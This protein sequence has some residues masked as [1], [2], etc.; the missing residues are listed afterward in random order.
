METG[1]MN[2][3]QMPI[4]VTPI[5]TAT[6]ATT[7]QT[8]NGEE[9]ASSAFAEILNGLTPRMQPQPEAPPTETPETVA[10]TATA[11]LAQQL[12]KVIA[13][14]ANVEPPEADAVQKPLLDLIPQEVVMSVAGAQL[15]LAQQ[16]IGRMPAANQNSDVQIDTVN[17]APASSGRPLLKTDAMEV[18]RNE[19]T[20]AMTTTGKVAS[21][22]VPL[23][24][25]T[26]LQIPSISATPSDGPVKSPAINISANQGQATEVASPER[27][28]IDDD[29]LAAANAKTVITVAPQEPSV[30][31][32]ALPQR[33]APQRPVAKVDAQPI[34]KAASTSVTQPLATTPVQQVT[35]AYSRT[36]PAASATHEAAALPE[37]A[38]R[39]TLAQP[40]QPAQP[41]NPDNALKEETVAPTK[42]ASARQEAVVLTAAQPD[43]PVTAVAT[44]VMQ[45]QAVVFAAAAPEVVE[46]MRVETVI[47][48]PV[49]QTPKQFLFIQESSQRRPVGTLE[50]QTA[51]EIPVAAPVTPVA[52]TKVQAVPAVSL[53]TPAAPVF[54][55]A[56]A[57][58][59]VVPAAS[60]ASVIAPG[61]P[62]ISVAPVATTSA[63]QSKK[64][65]DLTVDASQALH[66]ERSARP[67]VFTAPK[68]AVVIAASE[69]VRSE[70]V[71]KPSQQ[72]SPKAPAQKTMPAAAASVGIGTSDWATPKAEPAPQTMR[73]APLQ[74]I[75]EAY[76]QPLAVV[77]ASPAVTVTAAETIPSQLFDKVTGVNTDTA[78]KNSGTP[79]THEPEVQKVTAFTVPIAAALSEQPQ[80]SAT[81]TPI[82]RAVETG[83]LPIR[84]TVKANDGPVLVE[85]QHQHTPAAT[86]V[87]SAAKA[88]LV[89]AGA[90]KEMAAAT[91]G[92]DFGSSNNSRS[93][94][95]MNG[96]AHQTLPQQ[97]KAETAPSAAPVANSATSGVAEQVAKQVGEHFAKHE[98]KAGS[99]QIVIR[100]NPDNL[101]E[102]K[103]NLRMENQ[104]VTIEIVT[105]NRT[106][107]DSLLQN[108]D[109]LKESLAKQNI[110]MDSFDVSTGS[111]NQDNMAG[112][113]GRN[114]NDWQELAKNRQVQQ[115]QQGGYNVPKALVPE[116]LAYIPQRQ[117]TMLDVHF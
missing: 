60:V 24:K 23:E 77:S 56:A 103:V 80:V 86:E 49:L 87:K 111:N 4:E 35:E 114:Q 10:V 85:E 8:V 2:M 70:V 113:S 22:A 81:A 46:K 101:G 27:A 75:M 15:A 1:Q 28:D 7:A 97:S 90:V 100:L 76:S 40:A 78:V 62:A 54:P 116:K 59:P 57:K 11:T 37:Q 115:W 52:N 79:T 92:E 58:T 30:T 16:M 67:E 20:E 99:D 51:P 31:A 98:I 38:V 108:S 71:T 34:E 65:A 89:F 117:H 41:A 68:E 29:H 96:L 55:V 33:V 36:L 112:R 110:K 95:A 14:T 93:D 39:T 19:A 32:S 74:Q 5:V 3:I 50:V 73:T 18:A 6:A 105:D 43:K 106:V 12:T 64:P 69:E 63:V 61:L 88:E 82:Q 107:R 47:E 17:P 26:Q 66:T 53:A 25:S 9:P 94:Q 84:A 21:S 102:L 91:P 72:V 104:R 44:P 48:P 42:R 45:S 13:K 109:T 83:I